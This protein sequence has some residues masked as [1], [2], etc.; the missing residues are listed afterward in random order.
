MLL[1]TKSMELQ[2]LIEGKENREL[3][4]IRKFWTPV[5]SKRVA[6]ERHDLCY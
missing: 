3:G 2:A 5:L 6:F 1:V 4:L